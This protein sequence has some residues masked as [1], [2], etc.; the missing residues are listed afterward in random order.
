[1]KK[2]ARLKAKSAFTLVELV[3]VIAIIGVLAA[4]LV[5]ILVGTVRNAH[6]SSANSTAKDV[7]NAVNGW[8]T[9]KSAMNINANASENDGSVYVKIVADNGV[10]EDPVFVGD[11]WAGNVDEDELSAELKKHIEDTLGYRRMYSVGYMVG[12]RVGALYYY[13][14]GIAPKSAP[15]LADFD[16]TD[17]WPDENGYNAEGEVLGTSPIIVNY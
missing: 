5:P 9:K 12:G 15:A 8:L 16:K 2:F 11:F 6:V 7:R 13:D 10:Y 14:S 17:Y 4:I 1:M 3:V